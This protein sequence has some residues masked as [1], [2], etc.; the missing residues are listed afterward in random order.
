MP[1]AVNKLHG[2]AAVK[3]PTSSSER[4]KHYYHRHVVCPL[5]SLLIYPL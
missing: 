5:K 2:G 1:H 4:M 3:N